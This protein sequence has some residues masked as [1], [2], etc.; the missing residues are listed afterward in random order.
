MPLETATYLPQ[1]VP[2]N[3]AVT[4]PIATL[5]QHDN[6]VK[7]VLQNQFPNIGTVAVAATASQINAAC[8]ALASGVLSVPSNGTVASGELDLLGLI[9]GGGTIVAGR[10]EFKNTAA[11]AAPGA[12]AIVMT[13]SADASPTTAATLTAAGVF[14]AAASI[15][16]PSVL[17]GGNELLPVGM[18]VLWSGSVASI[19]AGWALCDGTGGTPNLV[20]KFVLGAGS[21]PVPGTNGGSFTAT[22]TADVQGSHSHGG[23][24]GTAGSHSHGGASGGYTLQVLDIPSHMHTATAASAD[25]GHSH[26][27]LLQSVTGLNSASGVSSTNSGPPASAGSTQVASANITTTVTVAATGGGGSH[28]HSISADGN[29]THTISAD[30]AHSH[31]VTV[32]YTPPY[33]ALAYIMKTT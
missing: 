3:P 7:Q 32:S 14:A 18:I 22:G 15:N 9:N 10:V 20:N 23:A 6:L 11:A 27:I 24:D 29:H 16:A 28:S 2:S 30:G 33:Y 4:D 19:P 25:S 26:P 12:L 5:Y 17:K 8:T 31:G 1:L 13:N 21:A